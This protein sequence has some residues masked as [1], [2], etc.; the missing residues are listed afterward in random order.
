MSRKLAGIVSAV[1][2]FSSPV[3][4]ESQAPMPGGKPGPYMVWEDKAMPDKRCEIYAGRSGQ[5]EDRCKQIYLQC[6]P[7]WQRKICGT[8]VAPVF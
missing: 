3:W 2:L 1:F 6:G 7:A 5:I 8:L 4:G